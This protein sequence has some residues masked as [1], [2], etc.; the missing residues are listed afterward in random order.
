MGAH[1]CN[2]NTWEVDAGA[3]GVH[4]HL[5]LQSE[6]KA[7]VDYIPFLNSPVL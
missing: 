5:E 7:A 3:S 2:P 6:F 4:S 1:A